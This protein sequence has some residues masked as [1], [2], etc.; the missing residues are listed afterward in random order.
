MRKPNALAAGLYL[1]LNLATGIFWFVVLTTLFFTGIG[2]SAIGVGLVLLYGMLELTRGA[3]ALERTWVRG[4]LRVDIPDP[5]F[6]PVDGS[7]QNRLKQRVTDPV[8]WRSFAYFLLMLPVGAIEFSL[9]VA[10]WSV[11]GSLLAV[12][13]WIEYSMFD[14]EFTGFWT[15]DSWDTALPLAAGGLAL[16]PLAL[17]ATRALGQ[18]HGGFAKSMLGPTR[19]ELLSVETERLQSSRARGVEAA[20]AERRRIERDL[21]DGAQQRLVAVAM[22]L[23]RAKSKMDSDPA[24][25]AQLLEEAHADAKLAIKELRDLARGIYPSVLGDRGLDAALSA[26]AARCPIEV[27]LQVDVEPRPPTSVESAAYFTVAEALTNVTKHS[28]GTK[29]QV[30]VN[31]TEAGVLVEVT[32]NGQGGAELRPGGGLAGLADRAATIDG[33]VVVV[34]PAGGPTVIRAELPC[35]W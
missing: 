16:L 33:V 1:L 11:V 2:L 31:R 13:F 15:V 27:Q 8:V 28:N 10:M 9:V 22:G 4:A 7:M 23:G 3:A 17:L 21:H 5:V 25:A 32:D 29:A 19:A 34:S 24:G 6:K 35:A 12:P 14:I 18:A 26:L 30:K 20:E